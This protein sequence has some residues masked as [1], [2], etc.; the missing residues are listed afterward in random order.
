MN[1]RDRLISELKNVDSVNIKLRKHLKTLSDSEIER[2]GEFLE[3]D[4]EIIFLIYIQFVSLPMK[5]QL[6]KLMFEA[7]S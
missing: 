3:I 5:Q 4:L 1:F 2:L 7:E 6:L